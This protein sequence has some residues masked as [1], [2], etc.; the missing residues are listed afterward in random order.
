M[1]RTRSKARQR[2]LEVLFEAQQRGTPAEE[3]LTNRAEKSQIEFNDYVRALVR[4]VTERQDEIDE[5]LATYARGWTLDRMPPV[6]L[7]VLRIG[8]WE[9]LHN[10]EIPDEVAVNEAVALVKEFS[11]DESPRFVHGLL[12]R[13]QKLKPSLG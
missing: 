6:D 11:T 8:A 9:L 2:A 13:L 7:V 12:G 3:V 5:L 10:E 4:G 1:K